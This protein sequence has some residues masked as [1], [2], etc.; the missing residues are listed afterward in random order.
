M[1]GGVIGNATVTVGADATGFLSDAE[2][3]VKS[4]AARLGQAIGKTTGQ[5]FSL[6]AQSVVTVGAT[7]IAAT[8]GTALSKGFARSVGLDTARGRLKGLGIEGKALADVMEQ[9]DIAVTDT[10]ATMA[11]GAQAASLMMSSGVKQGAS[12]QSALEAIV[13]LT[14]AS[15]A[16]MSEITPIMQKVAADT[17]NM[18]TA[19]SQLGTRGVNALAM[20]ADYFGV[21]QEEAAKMVKEGEVSFDQF[22]EALQQGTSAMGSAMSSTFSG[23]A[24]NIGSNLGRIGENFTGPLLE[25]S[26]IVMGPL[27]ESVRALAKGLSPIRAE[28]EGWLLPLAQQFADSIS[29]IDLTKLDFSG[30]SGPLEFFM[31]NLAGIGT[32]AA[33]ALGPFL[34]QL[35]LVGRYFSG[36]TGPIGLVIGFITAMFVESSAL[37]EAFSGIF[38]TIEPLL[39]ALGTLGGAVVQLITAFARLAGDALAD[40]ITTALPVLVDLLTAVLPVVTGIVGG[41]AQLIGAVTQSEGGIK[42][43]S[44]VIFTAVTAFG[45]WKAAQAAMSFGTLIAGL[46][47]TTAGFVKKTAAM[48]ADKAQTIILAGMYAKDMVV[49]LAKTAAGLVATAARWVAATAAMVA[50]KTAMVAVTVAQKA[51]T[52][53]Q[54]LFNAALSANPIGLV[55]AAITALVAGLVWFFTQTELGQEIWANF[56]Q[57]LAEAWE[58]VVKFLGEAWENIVSFFTTFGETVSTVWNDLWTGVSDFFTSFWEGIVSFFQ[59]ALQWVVDLFLN[60]TVYGLII[61]NWEEISAFFTA[62][63]DTI[64]NAVSTA[65]TTVGDWISSVTTTI[66]NIWNTVWTAISTFV[67][68]VWNTI[69]TAIQTAIN[70]VR[71]VITNVITFIQ[72]IWT[73][74]W[75]AISTT[76]QNVWNG[77]VSFVTNYINAVRNVITNVIN[78]IRTVWNNIWNGIKTFFSNVWSN[79]KNAASNFMNA[80]KNTFSNVVNFVKSVPDKIFGFF[81]NMGTLLLNSGKSLIDGFLNGIK[82]AWGNITGWVSGAME[83]LRGLWPFSPAKWGPF[84]GRGWVSYSGEALG[85]TFGESTADALKGSTKGITNQLD[86]IS[87]EFTAYS[88]IGAGLTDSLASGMLSGLTPVQRAAQTLAAAINDPMASL[89]VPGNLMSGVSIA[90]GSFTGVAG[91]ANG[92]PAAPSA[93]SAAAP[94]LVVQGPLIEVGSLQVDSEDRVRELAQELWTRAQRTDR[95]QGKINLGGTVR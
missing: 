89:G 57:F 84:S 28:F 88:N 49:A 47:K 94:T 43:L 66:S 80:V 93:A 64:V 85:K 29:R 86:N 12:L 71:D 54:W 46:A 69:L 51:A 39:P 37:R 19:I 20:L 25:A 1:A 76:A 34:Q 21:T 91:G 75:T 95:A 83:N 6:A 3:K 74:I 14:E 50:Q 61:Q 60:W 5:A 42:G 41:L 87:D 40:L 31:E 55:V 92:A 36:L 53:A 33:A 52:A 56:T 78:G 13:G 45:L 72:G 82:N 77:I 7:A 65:I 9:V 27:L 30:L 70:F 38:S 24:K 16:N 67:S 17:G 15:G 11:D 23:L 10:T 63:W 2:K 79:I 8:V 48:V 59:G 90:P 32:I 44:G 26:K 18:G 81:R 58:N 73:N 4:P 68:D 35:P 62:V 22:S